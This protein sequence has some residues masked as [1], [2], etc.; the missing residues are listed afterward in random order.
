MVA[1]DIEGRRLGPGFG[2]PSPSTHHSQFLI[3][4]NQNWTYPELVFI[5]EIDI[6]SI[7]RL[8]ASRFARTRHEKVFQT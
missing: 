6:L 2:K 8:R 1:V 4:S 7:Y 5:V 3:H